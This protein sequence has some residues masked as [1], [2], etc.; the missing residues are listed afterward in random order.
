M[1][2]WGN[3]RV[4]FKQWCILDLQQICEGVT[5]K[6]AGGGTLGSDHGK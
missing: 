5:F 1:V 2:R 6:G 3:S 4:T